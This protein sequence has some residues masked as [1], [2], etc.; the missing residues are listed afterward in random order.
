MKVKR[1]VALF[2][3]LVLALSLAAPAMAAEQPQGE[4]V[5]LGDGFYMIVT[6][7][8]LPMTRAGDTV[9]GQ[10]SG[11]VY[12]GTTQVGTITLT[13]EF[14]ISGATAKAT[15][16]NLS[17]T[18]ANGWT[19]TNAYTSRSGNT[20]TGTATFVNGSR[21]KVGTITLSCSPDGIVS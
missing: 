6:L 16:A 20:A 12:Y 3:T 18:E 13:A 10:K 14:D 9:T 8:Q 15:R 1:F 4:Y 2:C 5:D 19:C 11:T 21:Q 7:E 17:F